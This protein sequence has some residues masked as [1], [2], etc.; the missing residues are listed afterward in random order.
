MRRSAVVLP[1]AALGLA[2]VLFWFWDE[3]AGGVDGGMTEGETEE[4]LAGAVFD[5]P[6]A[7]IE[8]AGE[9]EI[10]S[11]APSVQGAPVGLGGPAGLEEKAEAF[12]QVFHRM[13]IEEG[14]REA[15]EIGTA[16]ATRLLHDSAQGR[17]LRELITETADSMLPCAV[18]DEA[19]LAGLDFN[20]EMCASTR[21]AHQLEHGDAWFGDMDSELT[22]ELRQGMENRPLD[23]P[24][25]MHAVR[26]AGNR[27]DEN[28]A[29]LVAEL[30][31]LRDQAVRDQ[32]LAFQEAARMRETIE[33]AR[34]EVGLWTVPRLSEVER[35]QELLP[36]YG[37]IAAEVR[38]A[39]TSY[40][41]NIRAL[42]A[43]RG[44]L[45]STD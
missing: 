39:Q 4:S 30:G 34:E 40:E 13:W 10:E 2:A 9:P 1:L 29:D 26:L 45:G 43:A 37:A 33:K 32:A 18:I 5:G 8:R 17:R 15:A 28:D 20:G 38:R 12:R 36:E 42:L 44:L 14:E 11:G 16:R 31:R 27:F 24:P 35:W 21:L 22:A 3:P 41:S 7:G 6:E 19:M 25:G 23:F